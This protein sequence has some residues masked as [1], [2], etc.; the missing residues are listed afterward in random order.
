MAKLAAES[1][2]ARLL[3]PASTPGGRGPSPHVSSCSSCWDTILGSTLLR[4]VTIGFMESTLDIAP[5]KAL[6]GSLVIG[7]Y[8]GHESCQHCGPLLKDLQ[9]LA[10]QRTNTSIILVPVGTTRVESKR[11]F[12][13][14]YAWLSVPYDGA[15]GISLVE[16]FQIRTVPALV[17]LDALGAVICIDGRARLAVDRL[18]RDF[19]WR[20]AVPHQCPTV[21]FDLPA[22][23]RPL[24]L[25]PP[26]MQPYPAPPGT[27]PQRFTLPPTTSPDPMA[28]VHTRAAAQPSEGLDGIADVHL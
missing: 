9:Q 22:R 11:Y 4:H 26:P 2:S 7:L 20:V 6:R 18:G 21:N 15:A 14:M 10:A 16:R 1:S 19:P 23:A 13:N 28:A 25:P 17:L 8:F 5:S 24:G 12:G 27:P 3:A